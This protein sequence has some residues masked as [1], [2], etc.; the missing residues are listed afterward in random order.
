L[1]SFNGFSGYPLLMLAIAGVV[2]VPAPA[3]AGSMGV[4]VPAYFSPGTGGSGG[5]GETDGWAQLAAAASQIPVTAIFNPN[6]GPLPGLPDPKYVAAMT[7]LENAGGEVVAYLPTFFTATPLA[8]VEGYLATYIGQY[9]N[10]INGFF[11]DQMTNDNV[12]SDLAYYHTLYTLIK[13]LSPSYQVIG[14]PG[15]NTVPDYL[16]PSTQGAD[17][18]V[19]YENKAQFYAG[20][21]PAPWTSGY[22]SNDFANIIHTQPSVPGMIADIA[23]AASRN[24]GSIYVT[25][26]VLPNPYAQLLSYW[27]QEVAAI[28]SVPEPGSLTLLASGALLITLAAAARRR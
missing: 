24:V 14:N 26:Q 16:T 22:P 7:N 20:T 3:G 5:P 6:S 21:A 1:R 9:G 28:K 25:D 27:D 4:L 18:L 15:T 10:L 23:L 12:A 11:V 19:T 2:A 17:T 13:S 8:T